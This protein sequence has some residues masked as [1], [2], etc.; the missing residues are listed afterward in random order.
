MKSKQGNLLKHLPRP[1]LD[2][3]VTGDLIPFI[4]AGFSTNC[5][6]LISSTMPD[7]AALGKAVASEM[8]DYEFDGNPI[9]ALSVY[10]ERYKRSVLVDTLRR[11]LQCNV[12]R[13][14]EAHRLLVKCFSGI[15][16]TTNFDTL[17]ESALVEEHANPIVVTS[18]DGL[19]TLNDK[20]TS[21]IKIHGD[22]NHPER[23]VVTESDYDL[24]INK[25]PLLCTFISSLFITKT[26]LLMGYSL[27]D[28]DLR[29][30]LRIVQDRLGVMSRP[31]YSIQV[32]AKK[33]DVSRFRRRGVD[34]INLPR[35][36]NKSY[37]EMIIEFLRQ[38]KEYLDEVSQRRVSSSIEDAKAQLLLS[39]EEN[40]LCFVFCSMSRIAFLR[41]VLNPPIIKSG[42]TPLWPDNIL[43]TGGLLR[44][45]A[46]DAAIKKS[47]IRMFDVSDMDKNLMPLL[48]DSLRNS[49]ART[50]LIKDSNSDCTLIDSLYESEVFKYHLATDSGEIMWEPEDFPEA[51][52]SRLASLMGERPSDRLASAR[53]LFKM[54]EYN[55]AIVSAWSE[56]ESYIRD[57]DP[58]MNH[59]AFI[60]CLNELV[61]GNRTLRSNSINVR[62]MRNE[63]VHG[64]RDAREKDARFAINVVENMLPKQAN[65][66]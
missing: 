39:S 63:V 41:E 44:W 19:S 22:L 66:F 36:R 25:N 4:G 46:L 51:L 62:K 32:G 20:G 12:I 59:S 26:M 28:R 64:V 8:S 37:K 50:I 27:D 3:L 38:L 54:G 14:G 40:K 56:L 47:H 7:W 23:L 21:V 10:E 15:I 52:N 9:E 31:I 55:A 61:N 16:C 43:A 45:R 18:E 6:G 17:I 24:F 33:E 60:E 42:A 34:V 35:P 65:R 29:Q 57:R 53:R 58:Y 11:V 13:P 5:E 30:L 2:S 1:L 49:R 48:Q